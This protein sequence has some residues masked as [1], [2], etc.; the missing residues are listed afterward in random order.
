MAH[1][2]VDDATIHS[3]QEQVAEICKSKGWW[4]DRSVGDLIALAHSEL[5]EALEAYRER[6]LAQWKEDAE[7]PCGFGSELADT[8]IR[9]LDMSAYLEIDLEHEIINKLAFNKTRP[10]RHGGKAL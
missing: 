8:V 3:L 9:I 1:N 4:T 2:L 10:Y 6:G 5:S 7:K